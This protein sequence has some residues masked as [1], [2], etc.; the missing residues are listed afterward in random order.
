MMSSRILTAISVAAF[1]FTASAAQAAMKTEWIDYTQGGKKLKGYLV[2]DDAKT[3]KRPAVFM[4][5]SRAGMSPEQVKLAEKWSTLG[6]VVFAADI[7][8]Y[9]EGILPKTA[10]EQVAQTDIY[11]KD[12]A[13]MKARAQAGFDTLLKNPMV[14]GSKIALVG[15]CFGGDVGVEF[16]STG[17]PLLANVAIHGSFEKDYAPGWAKNVKGRFVIEHGA[18][19]PVAP[20]AVVSKVVDE[21]RSAKVPFQLDVYSGTAHGFSAPKGKDEERA[22]SQS[23]DTA[24]RTFKEVFGI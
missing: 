6:Y 19:D 1:T 7:F 11:R 8:G 14:D 2:F 22:N 17:A 15:Y 5:P 12:R 4:V 3:G 16:G 9:G 10:P 13:L 21:L 24:A 20:L 23:F 18:E